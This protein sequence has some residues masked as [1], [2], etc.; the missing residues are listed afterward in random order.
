MRSLAEDINSPPPEPVKTQ[1][2]YQMNPA[3]IHDLSQKL[4]KG[5]ECASDLELTSMALNQCD[6]DMKK[7]TPQM[8]QEPNFIISGLVISFSVGTVFGL[9]HCFGLC[10]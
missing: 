7:A 1:D 4:V 8:W 6:A 5:E 9:T 2:L 10:N 3:Q